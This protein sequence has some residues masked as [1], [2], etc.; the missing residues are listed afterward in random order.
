VK[1]FRFHPAA[2]AE[3]KAAAEHYAAIIPQLGQRFYDSIDRLV[4]EVRAQPGLCRPFESPA[5]RH[6][7]AP[8]PYAVI[9]LDQP[10][11]IWIV[12][13]MHFKQRPGYW[14]ERLA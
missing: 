5:H 2:R 6:F 8:F 7:R 9:Y 13:I 1:P 10:A 3:L 11:E 12:A 14:R 4:R